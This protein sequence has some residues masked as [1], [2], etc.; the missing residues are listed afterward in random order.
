MVISCRKIPG[1]STASICWRLF[2]ASHARLELSLDP[3]TPRSIPKLA[4][5]LA[6]TDQDA[7]VDTTAAETEW[8]D[9]TG[10]G[11]VLKKAREKRSSVCT[12]QRQAQALE[13]R[14]VDTRKAQ[15]YTP[16]G[17]KV[18]QCRTYGR[19]I[20]VLIVYTSLVSGMCRLYATCRTRKMSVRYYC[21]PL[22]LWA[23]YFFG[24]SG[25][26]FS[27]KFHFQAAPVQQYICFPVVEVGECRG[28]VNSGTWIVLCC[29][30]R[31]DAHPGTWQRVCVTRRA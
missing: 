11:G 22:F 21:N 4:L 13:K 25:S 9:L 23:R 26:L 29:S 6:M 16:V 5:T 15:Q 19:D 31:L 12:A 20:C 17:C 14:W 8:I 24:H 27:A 2:E 30:Q 28:G 1:P 18:F 3:T 7:P 10:D